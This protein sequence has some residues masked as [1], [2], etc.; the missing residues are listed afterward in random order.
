M[1][2]GIAVVTKDLKKRYKLGKIVV[3]ALRGVD[4][5]IKQGEFIAI[6]GPSGSGK[7]TLLHLIGAL[8][9][10]TEGKVFIGGLDIARLSDNQLAKLRNRR[11]GFVF[12][13][14]NLISRMDVLSNVEMPLIVRGLSRT[15]R[16]AKA[17]QL[18]EMV[19]LGDKLD[20][21]PMEISGGE[22]QRVGIARALVT[23][24]VLVLG[25]EL[26]GNL[27]T[28]TS[29]DVLE[30]LRRM[31]EEFGTTFVL[32]THD[33][34]VAALTDRIVRLRDGMIVED[35]GQILAMPV[36]AVVGEK[37]APTISI[38]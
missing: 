3:N 16:R 13:A 27:D 1:D 23:D 5:E 22:Q 4:L 18:L 11:I 20:R 2:N 8:D 17:R 14:Y 31:N 35:T 37:I 38:G 7:S 21:T 15:K 24:P 36:G 12:Q 33:L 28:Q 10:P 6:V 32:V 29:R 19:G 9:R 34:E 30:I 25:D 26:T